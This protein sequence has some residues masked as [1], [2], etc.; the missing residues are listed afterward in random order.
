MNIYHTFALL[1][2]SVLFI[3]IYLSYKIDRVRRI[4]SIFL[5]FIFGAY[6]FSGLLPVIRTPQS[7]EESKLKKLSNILFVVFWLFFT[8]LMAI[9]WVTYR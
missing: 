7:S 2:F 6:A 9:I 1:V 3:R 5:K 8:A 4:D